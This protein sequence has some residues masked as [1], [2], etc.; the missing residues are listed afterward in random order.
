LVYNASIGPVAWRSAPG[1]GEAR[2]CRHGAHSQVKFM[3]ILAGEHKGRKL[4]SPPAGPG[5]RP[6][7]GMVKKSLFDII[8]ARL[9]GA[10]VLDL[11][12]GTGTL[13]LEA[14]SRGASAC[15]FAERDR[16]VV[17]RLRRNIEAL[18]AAER[19]LVWCGDIPARLTGWLDAW[20]G[21]ADLAFVDPPYAQARAWSW[22]AVAESL[23]A[24]LS[25]SLRTGGLVAVRLPG[26][27]QP[28]QHL[29]GLEMHR[30]RAYGGMAVALYA[31]RKES[32]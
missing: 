28:P 2:T 20:P 3:R 21:R 8:S 4:L 1:L 25:G 19:C 18:G 12:C 27:V 16:R 15:V 32:E 11:Y 9:A 30:M 13:G 14:L 23:F 10:T 5:I 6:I 22:P 29:A 17:S 24:P 26:K 31:G 7:T